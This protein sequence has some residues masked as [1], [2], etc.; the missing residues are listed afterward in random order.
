MLYS[1]FAAILARYSQNFPQQIRFV[2][3]SFLHS[4]GKRSQHKPTRTLSL[5]SNESIPSR[6]GT[7]S[8][9]DSVSNTP[10]L[11]A[12]TSNAD[13]SSISTPQDVSAM[14]ETQKWKSGRLRHVRSSIG[15]YNENVLS[16]SARES[17][18]GKNEADGS[19]TISGNNAIGSGDGGHEQLVRKSMKLLSS[20]WISSSLPGENMKRSIEEKRTTHRRKSTRK[21]VIERAN[22]IAKTTRSV[23]GKRGRETTEAGIGK[24]QNIKGGSKNILQSEYSMTLPFEGPS[25]K[26]AE[27][28]NTLDSTMVSSAVGSERVSNKRPRAKRWLEQGLYVGQDRDFDPRLTETK[29]KL[30]RL[31]DRRP[32]TEHR[33]TLP[34]PMFAGQR[35]V[36]TGRNFKLP[37]DIF[38]PLPPGQPRP[39]EWKKT[40]KSKSPAKNS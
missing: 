25:R 34:M 38:S 26:R 14:A 10:S 6:S 8:A 15:S 17:A 30:K 31:S 18:R 32:L 12:P 3:L 11:T 23:I 9:S 5:D 24:M 33:A 28:L 36:E 20:E 13:T 4:L 37:F 16:G 29:N 35:T 22:F 19:Q 2:M 40:H 39:E 1:H 21:T 7:R 27:R